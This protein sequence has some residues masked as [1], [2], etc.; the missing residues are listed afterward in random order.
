M[1]QYITSETAQMTGWLLAA[2]VWA[3]TGTVGF[4]HLL[5]P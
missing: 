1:K 2:L 4:G 3:V 5:S